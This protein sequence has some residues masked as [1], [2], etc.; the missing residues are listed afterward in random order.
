MGNFVENEMESWHRQNDVPINNS[1]RE[2][3]RQ[4]G[5]QW[6]RDNDVYRGPD[7]SKVMEEVLAE[8]KEKRKHDEFIEMYTEEGWDPFDYVSML[9]RGRPTSRRHFME[10]NPDYVGPKPD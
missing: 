8:L 10:R 3:Y 7:R 6:N 5:D 1:D 4:F 2:F 9:F